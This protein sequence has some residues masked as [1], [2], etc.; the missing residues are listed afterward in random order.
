MGATDEPRDILLAQR[1]AMRRSFRNYLPRSF[2]FH[3]DLFRDAVVGMLEEL[4]LEARADELDAY[5]RAQWQRHK[6][7]FCLRE[8]VVET[9][10]ELRQRG[11]H[12]GMVSNID[13]DQLEH[14]LEVAGIADLFD[15]VLSSEQA[16]SCKPDPLIYQIALK[17][18]GCAPH[19]ALFVGDTL[20]Q[21]IAGARQAGLRSVLI[22]H[23]EDR[24]PPTDGPSPD[25]IIRSV[26]EVL[27]LLDS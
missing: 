26:P 27:K 22:W 14:L 5:R 19:E 20:R 11:L 4:G 2:Y 8:G 13:D 1:D 7:D 23:R 12:V 3:R 21:D 10:K 24:E 16:Q 15:S 6:R 25:H 9:L 17:R 18:A